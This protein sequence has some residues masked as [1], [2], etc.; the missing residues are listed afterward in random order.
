MKESEVKANIY[1]IDLVLN[2]SI[3]TYLQTK[4]KIY[5]SRRLLNIFTNGKTKYLTTLH[6]Q[7]I[8]ISRVG[9][10]LKALRDNNISLEDYLNVA[11]DVEV[12]DNDLMYV[13]SKQISN[14]DVDNFINSIKEVLNNKDKLEGGDIVEQDQSNEAKPRQ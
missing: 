14:N 11:R 9:S 10:I 7:D 2:G 12:K 5:N 1:K 4:D 6:I 13:T 8:L 3:A